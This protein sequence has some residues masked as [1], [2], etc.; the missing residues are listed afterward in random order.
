MSDLQPRG[1][2]NISHCKLTEGSRREGRFTLELKA[3]FTLKL[4]F[5]DKQTFD[6]WN[7]VMI[8][9]RVNSRAV[10]VLSTDLCKCAADSKTKL[11][12]SKKHLS[13]LT[14]EDMKPH[15]KQQIGL[16]TS[17]DYHLEQG[18][19][20][21]QIY[22][23]V[24]EELPIKKPSL[25]YLGALLVGVLSTGWFSLELLNVALLCLLFLFIKHTLTPVE[26][27]LTRSHFKA[28]AL[29]HASIGEI[30][31]V[32]NNSS[33]R[34]L[35]EPHSIAIESVNP[36]FFTL[37]YDTTDGQVLQEL[38]R[39]NAGDETSMY[40]IESSRQTM[41]HAFLMEDYSFNC[42][43]ATKVIHYGITVGD[44]D[45]TVGNT[46]TL[47]CLKTCVESLLLPKSEAFTPR[48]SRLS[49]TETEPASDEEESPEEPIGEFASLPEAERR[50]AMK[51]CEDLAPVLKDVER[52]LT[53]TQGWE[54]IKL[55]SDI[56]TGFRRPAAGGLYVIKG[57]G[58]LSFSRE[59][60]LSLLK[61][62]TRKTDYDEMFESGH[63]IQV[64]TGDMEIV[65]QRFKKQFPASGRDFCIL[66]RRITMPNG[67]IIA[68][69]ASTTHPSCPP[70]KGL[71]RATLHM[72][73]FV[74]EALGETS[75]KVSYLTYVDLGGSVPGSIANMVQKKQPLVVEAIGRA[76]ARSN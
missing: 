48:Q 34:H 54:P 15:Y 75:T 13:E 71:V 51:Y 66:Q 29:I 47:S 46:K 2:L 17:K 12:E 57:T 33:I 31:S 61:D 73:A 30:Y 27:K 41:K 16:F 14:I 63:S 23:S 8:T 36:G 52:Y 64:I 49:K 58:V 37:R 26:P 7:S 1:M 53:D 59:R 9:P 72:G 70:V 44:T 65:Y 42:K 62:L 76:L 60:I 22:M 25:L 35:W 40:Y 39:L 11:R 28:V 38:V 3:S 55:S 68:V 50:V 32:L 19:T 10:E 6:Q 56:V 24:G 74:L 18:H 69:A 4:E 45:P 5:P 43:T 20:G 21:S 67:S